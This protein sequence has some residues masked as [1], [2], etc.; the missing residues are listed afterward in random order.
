[1]E[2]KALGLVEVAGLAP[3]IE[4]CDI[5]I[6]T[7]NVQIVEIEN[8]KGGGYTVI[9]V[10]GDVGAVQ[11]ACKAGEAYAV[12]CNKLVSVKVIPRPADGTEQFFAKHE[13][14]RAVW[15]RK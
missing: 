7:A 5:M 12:E 15:Y 11:A 1:M 3:A 6:K 9:K 4:T 13:D 8:T 14:N 10:E 2:K